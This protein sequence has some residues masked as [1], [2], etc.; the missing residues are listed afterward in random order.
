MK[1]TVLARRKAPPRDSLNE[2]FLVD[3]NWN[4]Y[5]YYT[6]CGIFYL[7]QKKLKM[8]NAANRIILRSRRYGL[9]RGDGSRSACKKPPP[10]LIIAKLFIFSFLHWCST[11]MS[12][13][14]VIRKD[15]TMLV[16]NNGDSVLVSREQPVIV[17]G[18]NNTIIVGDENKQSED[19]INCSPNQQLNDSQSLEWGKLIQGTLIIAL[20][21]FSII[22]VGHPGALKTFLDTLK[23]IIHRGLF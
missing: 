1:F 17:N 4:D 14:A 9:R 20:L 19:H 16:H 8:M 11:N 3:D 6:L 21:L 23:E 15:K 12:Y 7:D 13:A 18:D 2:V 10:W 5:S 22:K